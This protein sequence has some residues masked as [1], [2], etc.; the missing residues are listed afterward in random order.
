M[1]ALFVCFLIAG[2]FYVALGKLSET[3]AFLAAWVPWLKWITIGFGIALAL[4]ILIVLIRKIL[5]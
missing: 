3:Y 1:I 2:I 5:K 4:M